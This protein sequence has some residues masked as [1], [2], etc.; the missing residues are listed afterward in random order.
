VVTTVLSV[1][2]AL[3]FAWS[4]PISTLITGAENKTLLEEKIGLARSFSMM[5]EAERE[6]LLEQVLLVPNR[7]AIEYYKQVG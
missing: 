3:R 6:K 2:D 1:A 4:L 7:T 5:S